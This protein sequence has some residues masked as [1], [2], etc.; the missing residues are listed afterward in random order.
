MSQIN[1]DASVLSSFSPEF[2]GLRFF[3]FYEVNFYD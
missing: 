1:L 2:P 3:F